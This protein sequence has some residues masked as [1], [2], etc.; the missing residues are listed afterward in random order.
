MCHGVIVT[1]P[2]LQGLYILQD[3]SRAEVARSHH[4]QQAT[5]DPT[6]RTAVHNCTRGLE[7]L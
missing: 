5:E 3:V 2:V 7:S 4:S 6:T 1:W